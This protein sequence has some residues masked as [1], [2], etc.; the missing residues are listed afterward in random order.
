MNIGKI[1][2]YD[3]E[4]VFLFSRNKRFHL[5][6]LHLYRIGKAQNMPVV[7]GRLVIFRRICNMQEKLF[8]QYSVQWGQISFFFSAKLPTL[9]IQK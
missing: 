8:I 7:A 9:F 5:L 1:T 2:Q 4:K 6:K 3:E